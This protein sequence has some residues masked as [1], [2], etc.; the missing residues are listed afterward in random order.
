MK[1]RSKIRFFGY[2]FIVCCIAGKAQSIQVNARLDTTAILIGDQITLHV[3]WEKKNDISVKFP[4]WDDALP[5]QFEI[6]DVSPVDSVS[7]TAG[8]MHFSQNVLITSFDS[9]RHELPSILFPFSDNGR[10]DTIRTIPIYLDV[11]V[12]PT[13]TLK[14]IV[15]IK[16]IYQLPIGWADVYPW[17]ILCGIILATLALAGFIVYAVIRKRRNQPIFGVSKPEEPP[18]IIA[19]RKLDQL[20]NEKLWQ[21]NQTKEYYTRLTD[22]VRTYIEK[23]F[24]V[25]AMEMTSEEILAGLEKSSFEDNNLKNCLRQLLSL[26]DLVKFAKINPLPD[27]NET[28]MLDSYLFVNNTKIELVETDANGAPGQYKKRKIS[29]ISFKRKEKSIKQN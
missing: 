23:R 13:D 21:H 15:D 6:L 4:Q 2:F 14:N 18:H 1:R 20:R 22:I 26:A 17:L 24:G 12:I 7:A 16:P 25:N 5:P 11:L 19:L 10:T 9:G 3:E 29:G 27:E 8:M 28:S